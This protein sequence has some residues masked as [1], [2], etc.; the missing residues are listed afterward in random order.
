MMA[1]LVEI[2]YISFLKYP[3]LSTTHTGTLR[4]RWYLI[5]FDLN[6]TLKT[7]PAHKFNHQY[8]CIFHANHDRDK[9][10]SDKYSR[11]WP[12]WWKNTIYPSSNIHIYQQLIQFP[13]TCKT[14]YKSMS[15]EMTWL[16]YLILQPLQDLS[17]LNPFIQPTTQDQNLT[18]TPG[19]IP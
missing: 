3:Y 10:K 8:Y 19:R 12:D 7:N 16:I 11:W 17:I 1:R 13:P 6:I 2:H 4:A 14:Y 5:Q 9:N 18:T 15:N